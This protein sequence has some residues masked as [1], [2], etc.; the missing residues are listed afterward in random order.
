[1]LRITWK[2]T[3]IDTITTIRCFEFWS[4]SPPPAAAGAHTFNPNKQIQNAHDHPTHQLNF[5]GRFGLTVC[6]HLFFCA[7]EVKSLISAEWNEWSWELQAEARKL[8]PDFL[9]FGTSST[10]LNKQTRMQLK[11]AM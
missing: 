9:C 11:S 1:M 3:Y 4:A 5:M 10:Q 8:K 7:M 6:R 2:T